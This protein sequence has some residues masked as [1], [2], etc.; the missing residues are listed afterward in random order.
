MSKNFLKN[1]VFVF[2]VYWLLIVYS[3]RIC[4]CSMSN[5]L[6]R[7]LMIQCL[8]FLVVIC[9]DVWANRGRQTQKLVCRVAAEHLVKICITDTK[10][11]TCTDDCHI[12]CCDLLWC[13]SKP[14]AE[15]NKRSIILLCRGAAEH[16]WE[17]ICIFDAL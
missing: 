6:S 3:C 10:Q 8:S 4:I 11:L 17:K 1:L 2:V 14:R 13:L 7:V 5:G 9:F 15:Q 16:L 12:T